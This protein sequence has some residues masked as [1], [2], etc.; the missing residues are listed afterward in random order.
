MSQFNALRLL[1]NCPFISTYHVLQL[2]SA[3]SHILMRPCLQDNIMIGEIELIWQRNSL[4]YIVFTAWPFTILML[5]FP[6][7]LSLSHY[8]YVLRS[9]KIRSTT[10]FSNICFRF[11]RSWLVLLFIF[12]YRLLRRRWAVFVYSSRFEM[13]WPICLF[14]LFCQLLL[15]LTR[16]LQ[17]PSCSALSI[18]VV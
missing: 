8:S 18:Q 3:Q 7:I 2:I 11:A 16:K 12:F 4:V 6:V 9:L 13:R 14:I 1:Y 10:T 5:L 17:T 15:D